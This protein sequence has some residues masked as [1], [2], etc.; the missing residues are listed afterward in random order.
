MGAADGGE[1]AGQE[2]EG[3]E[4]SEG[5]EDEEGIESEED[6]EG[7]E[8]AAKR[9]S[10]GRDCVGRGADDDASFPLAAAT[11]PL[12]ASASPRGWRLAR[13]TEQPTQRGCKFGSERLER[14]LRGQR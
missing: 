13:R 14:R 9:G 5:E 12:R 10:H 3:E 2:D 8:A 4:G 6:E 1:A 7:E 11:P